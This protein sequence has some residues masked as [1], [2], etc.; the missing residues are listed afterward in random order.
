VVVLASAADLNA[1]DGQARIRCAAS[2][3]TDALIDA[4]HRDAQ[5]HSVLTETDAAT[6]PEGGST[7]V[8]VKLS[9]QPDSDLLVSVGFI[10]GPTNLVVQ[11]GGSLTFTPSNWDSYQAVSVAAQPDSDILN[12]QAILRCN[13]AGWTGKDVLVTQLDNGI[14]P[15][16]PPA[17]SSQPASLSVVGG[18]GAWFG[19]AVSGT[20]PFYYQWMKNGT[21]LP[22]ATDSALLLTN[23]VRRDSGLYS[24]LVTNLAGVRLSSAATLIVRV[25]QELAPVV[26]SGDGSL[27]LRFGD[28]DGGWLTPDDLVGFEV[29]ASGDLLNWVTLTN[30]LTLTNGQAL[31]LDTDCTNLP[32]RF[33]HIIEH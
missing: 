18:G 26:R 10:S 22:G 25:P 5:F 28:A 14:P 29:L 13:A 31:L 16:N 12:D 9:N 4:F 27:T 3:C 15:P 8:R 1:L 19:I 2:G 17:V 20:A 33:Y 30:A 21:N 11:S 6:A 24:V 23:V 32:V 7:I